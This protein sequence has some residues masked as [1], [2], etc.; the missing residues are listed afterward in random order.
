[1]SILGVQLME[2]EQRTLAQKGTRPSKAAVE[3]ALSVWIGADWRHGHWLM[4]KT[5]VRALV[6]QWETEMRHA[7]L[8]AWRIDHPRKRPPTARRKR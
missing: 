4:D 2:A 5:K 6:K 3:A 1:M 7:L 8:A